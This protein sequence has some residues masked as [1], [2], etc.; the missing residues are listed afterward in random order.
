MNKNNKND[1]YGKY[2]RIYYGG[3][4]R[5]AGVGNEGLIWRGSKILLVLL[6]LIQHDD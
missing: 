4:M 3:S 5:V 2:Y 1:Y 6:Y